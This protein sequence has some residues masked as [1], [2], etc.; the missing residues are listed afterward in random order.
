MEDN[1]KRMTMFLVLPALLLAMPSR[2]GM[3]SPE[4]VYP[5][6]VEVAGPNK[7]KGFSQLETVCILMDFP[8]NHADTVA[9]SPAR[10][11]SMLYSTGV[12]TG[13]QYRQGSLNDFFFENS[14]GNFHVLGGIA[15]NRWF[16]STYNYSRYDDGNYMLGTGGQLADENVAQVDASVDFSQYDLNHDGHI[17]AMFMV[18][19]GSDGADDGNVHHCWSHAIPYFNYTTNDGVVIDGVTNVPEFAMVTP[20]R[21]TTMCCIAVMCHEMGHLV[22]LPDLYDYSRNDWGPGYWGLMSYGA[23]GAGGN[24]PWSPS[25]LEAWSMIEAGFAS[26]QVITHDTF[27]LHI[28]DVET[29][30]VIYKVWRNGV[31]TDSCFLLENRQ[32]KGFDTPLPGSGLL[33]WHIDYNEG[34]YYDVVDLEED[35]T[36]HLSH[37]FGYRPDPHVY[38]PEMG[39]ASDPLPGTW[40]RE[41]FDNLSKPS[42]KNNHNQP[43]NVNV[44]NIHMLGDTVVCDVWFGASGI[45]DRSELAVE[46]DLSLAPNPAR[47]QTRISYTLPVSGPVCLGLY[48]VAGN[49]V[50]RLAQGLQQAGTHRLLVDSRSLAPGIYV[51]RLESSGT[52]TATKL[53]LE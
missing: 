6:G 2:P 42:S 4:P 33:I 40:N 14:Y 26:P 21:E 1:V 43:T 36:D 28:L 51:L 8:D 45:Q 22:G 29:H 31:N 19:A 13:Q 15:G 16:R 24:T 10:F 25:H 34:G 7:L 53:V 9:R 18:H 50:R 49:L 12:Y 52:R 27:D 23:W 5:K 47:G 38:H 30:P 3:G 44:T 11:D 46:R 17:D 37:G 48:D 20:V 35:S 32:Q 41:R 39:A